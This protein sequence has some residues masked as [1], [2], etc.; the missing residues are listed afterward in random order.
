MS[1]NHL[2]AEMTKDVFHNDPASN[3]VNM[4]INESVEIVIMAVAGTA[5]QGP[6]INLHQALDAAGASE[7]P[8]LTDVYFIEEG[9][10]ATE[11]GNPTRMHIDPKASSIDLSAKG[12]KYI[13]V[14]IP[15][16]SA[17]LD[18]NGGFAWLRA[19]ITGTY[20][21]AFYQAH[22]SRFVG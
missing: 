7:K 5:G 22:A 9:N 8:V 15:V 10:D 4:G 19:A 11:L 1:G 6:V 20:D 21:W 14:R 12:D 17:Q 2:L 13:I 3:R 16:R 18:P